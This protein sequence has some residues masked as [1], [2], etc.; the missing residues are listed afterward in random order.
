MNFNHYRITK[1]DPKNVKFI[2]KRCFDSCINFEYSI[3]IEKIEKRRKIIEYEYILLLL[4]INF[5]FNLMTSYGYET[6]YSLVKS[7]NT[8]AN[9]QD[10]NEAGLFIAS[11]S[12]ESSDR[13]ARDKGELSGRSGEPRK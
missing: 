11:V 13:S 5:N 10:E 8:Y 2:D 12:G 4:P 1:C 7:E 3:T 6:R 9:K